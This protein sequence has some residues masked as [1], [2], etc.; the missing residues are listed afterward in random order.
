MTYKPFLISCVL[1]QTVTFIRGQ[2]RLTLKGLINE[3][4]LID[5]VVEVDKPE[6]SFRRWAS[7]VL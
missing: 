7:K 4:E 1:Y 2:C 3:T 5:K 6:R